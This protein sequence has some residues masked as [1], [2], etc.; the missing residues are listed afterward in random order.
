MNRRSELLLLEYKQACAY[1]GVAL[2]TNAP[3]SVPLDT[4]TEFRSL[5]L[6]PGTTIYCEVRYHTLVAFIRPKT[7][8]ELMGI[9]VG[10]AVGKSE[11]GPL[12]V[13]LDTPI[14]P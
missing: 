14:Y 9:S 4:T 3:D 2:P 13:R 10:V 5:V 11:M 1:S 7:C 12:M 8:D 6:T